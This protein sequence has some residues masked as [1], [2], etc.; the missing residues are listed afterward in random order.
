M[1]VKTTTTEYKFGT[2]ITIF[3]VVKKEELLE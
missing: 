3:T 2:Y 1:K